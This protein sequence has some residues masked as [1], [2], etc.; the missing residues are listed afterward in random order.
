MDSGDLAY[1]DECQNE[2][3][4]IQYYSKKIIWKWNW[5]IKIKI[6]SLFVDIF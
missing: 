6:S 2:P 3:L 4:S 5:K 1:A